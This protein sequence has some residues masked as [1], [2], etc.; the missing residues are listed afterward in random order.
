MICGFGTTSSTVHGLE[1][2]LLHDFYVFCLLSV[3]KNL[4]VSLLQLSIEEV[5]TALKSQNKTAIVFAQK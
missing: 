3:I 5:I 1:Q 4:K 2:I